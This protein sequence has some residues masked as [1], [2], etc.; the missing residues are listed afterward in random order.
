M[1]PLK[2]LH[3]ENRILL[4]NYEQSWY[5]HNTKEFLQRIS[6]LKNKE[7]IPNKIRHLILD[8]DSCEY[9]YDDFISYSTFPDIGMFEISTRVIKYYQKF[10]LHSTCVAKQKFDNYD[11][12]LIDFKELK[13]DIF[14]LRSLFKNL[15]IVCNVEYNADL[16]SLNYYRKE[17]NDFLNTLCRE[18]DNIKIVNPNDLINKDNPSVD[19]ID[20]N[21][22]N[23][24]F[25]QTMVN[26]YF[27]ILQ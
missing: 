14:E 19:L 6:F 21:H 9:A 12:K 16:M 18:Y 2:K 4:T 10:C 11:D 22:F 5:A 26:H 8:I 7:N 3:K 20:N 23:E 24:R 25:T 1:S 15:I 17:L 13:N 27:N